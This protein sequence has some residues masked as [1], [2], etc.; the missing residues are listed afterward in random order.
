MEAELAALA[1]SG[2]TTVVTL[3]VSDAWEQMRE[4]VAR[5]FAGGD[6]GTSAD[7]E[8]R[9]SRD[10]LLVARAAGDEDAVADVEEEWRLRLRRVLRAD[11]SA[12]RELRELLDECDPQRSHAPSVS[13]HNTISGTVNGPAFQGQQ[14]SGLTFSSEPPRSSGRAAPSE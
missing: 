10:E 11:P 8:L 3:M 14:F 12:A 9:A 13:V 1:A 5:L 7:E 4:R 6:E 2:A